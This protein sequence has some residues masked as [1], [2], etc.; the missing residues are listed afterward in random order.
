V[1]LDL[2]QLGCLITV[3]T[4]VWAGLYTD[5]RLGVGMIL[6]G[7]VVFAAALWVEHE[8]DG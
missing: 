8:V 2:I 7:L 6:T 5:S 3:V 1:V 4:G